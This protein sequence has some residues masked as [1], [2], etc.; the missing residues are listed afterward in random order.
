[1][2]LIAD[3]TS[4]AVTKSGLV[5]TCLCNNLSIPSLT[6]SILFCTLSDASIL[7]SSNISFTLLSNCLSEMF[8]FFKK[9]LKAPILFAFGCCL[10]IPLATST[11]NI[12]SA[13]LISLMPSC[14]ICPTSLLG[15]FIDGLKY[16]FIDRS[17]LTSLT[18]PLF[19]YLMLSNA[20]FKELS[21]SSK[22]SEVFSRYFIHCFFHLTSASGSELSLAFFNV[23]IPLSI[24]FVN[25]KYFLELIIALDVSSTGSLATSSNLPLSSSTSST[26]PCAT[27]FALRNNLDNAFT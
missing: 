16:A 26:S 4:G 19:E 9:V 18:L 25:S 14:L 13:S 17:C 5:I 11:A 6:S 10:A 7:K 21:K 23:S 22:L 20:L 24:S 3:S 2:P 27:S 1:M 8:S 15:G 12:P